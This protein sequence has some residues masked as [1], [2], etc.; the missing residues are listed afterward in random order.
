MPGLHM[1]GRTK[2][3][4]TQ[5]HTDTPRLP[6]EPR[7][8]QEAVGPQSRAVSQAQQVSTKPAGLT[9]SPRLPTT[10]QAPGKGE[11]WLASEAASMG[12][13]PACLHAGPCELWLGP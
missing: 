5:E 12:W 4:D 3:A 8:W 6:R 2:P 7:R 11:K 9:C 1:L 10:A 13:T